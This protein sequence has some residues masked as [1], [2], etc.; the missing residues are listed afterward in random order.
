MTAREFRLSI[1]GAGQGGLALLQV[2]K[3]DDNID[4]VAISDSNPNAPALQLA[5]SRGVAVCLNIEQLPVCD[6]AINVTGSHQVTELLRQHFSTDVEIMEGKAAH[7][8]Y[9]QVCKRKAEKEQVERM[10]V[11][12]EKL[13][14]VGRQLNSFNSLDKML[15]LVLCEALQLTS[16]YDLSL[17]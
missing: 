2:L 7:F 16:W 11:E 1:V 4:V 13:N 9:D 17:R 3:G 6:M 14:A 12:I 15:D 5:R 10:L 8:F